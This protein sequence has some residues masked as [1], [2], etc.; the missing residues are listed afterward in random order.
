MGSAAKAAGCCVFVIL[1]TCKTNQI[2]GSHHLS[3][4]KV[5][6]QVTS[7]IANGCYKMGGKNLQVCSVSSA[8]SMEMSWHGVLEIQLTL[9]LGTP[10]LSMGKWIWGTQIWWPGLCGWGNDRAAL[11]EHLKKTKDL[12]AFLKWK[13]GTSDTSYK[14]GIMGLG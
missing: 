4:N 6:L 13:C 2:W 14:S 1:C 7:L 3:W 12:T 5:F 9:S 8:P 10:E 11:C